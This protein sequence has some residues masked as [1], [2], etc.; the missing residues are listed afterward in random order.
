[1]AFSYGPVTSCQTCGSKDLESVIFLAYLP[2][3]NV[4]SPLDRA[5]DQEQW[6]PAEMLR[7]P[8]CTLVQL[9]YVADP[10]LVFPPEYPYTSG[11]TKI[12]R[13][14]FADLYKNVKQ[15]M[16]LKPE[17]FVIDI[18]SNDGTLLK[19]FKNG[20]HKVLGIEPS[21]AAKLAEKDDIETMMAFFGTESTDEVLRTHGQA[22]VITAANVFAHILA[23]NSVVEN[24]KR[25][26][27]PE[28]VFVSESHY[29]LGLIET[30]QYDTIYH[31]HLRYYSLQSIKFLLE[32][33]GFRV[34]RVQRI[35]THG[36]SIRVYAALSDRFEPDGSVEDLLKV[37]DQ[38][39]LTGTGWTKPFR[40]GVVRSKLELYR[41]LA[42]IKSKGQKI[43]G[44]SAPSRASTLVNYAGLDDEL[45]ECVMEIKGSKKIGKYLPG[46]NIPVLEESKL[47]ADQPPYAL[48]LSWHIATELMAN[49]K[50]RG[51]KGDFIIPLPIPR[52]VKNSEV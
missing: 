41:I 20:G 27:K 7:C 4:M 25:L 10:S 11:T 29:L 18:G 37:E 35:P 16:D 1:M 2:S 22:D 49:L 19:N 46:R 36:G 39:G 51:Y 48:L 30:L 50:K 14:N 43:Y 12:L 28:G 21:L 38:A 33:H 13:E 8:R 31:E 32:K 9:G 6:F 26:L 44:I 15:L 40:E 23:P 3:V 52:I 34:F 42:D 24:I 17:N 47:Y 45:I 5:H